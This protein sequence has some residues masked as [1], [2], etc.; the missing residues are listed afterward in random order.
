MVLVVEILVF[1]SLL[2]FLLRCFRFVVVVV[3]N[4]E[5]MGKNLSRG[6]RRLNS[7]CSKIMTNDGELAAGH[8]RP[9][10][11]RWAKIFRSFLGE[12]TN[13]TGSNLQYELRSSA[14]DVRK[15]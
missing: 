6:L 2:S 8:A 4:G 7:C 3:F 10:K 13:F 9:N 1:I 12:D 11:V 15:K 14:E 5:V